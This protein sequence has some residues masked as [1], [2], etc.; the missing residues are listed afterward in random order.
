MFRMAIKTKTE[1]Y[2]NYENIVG[3]DLAS[4]PD[5]ILVGF[6]DKTELSYSKKDIIR[7]WVESAEE[8]TE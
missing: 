4:N 2:L 8:E 7:I 5:F 6:A 1:G 3:Y